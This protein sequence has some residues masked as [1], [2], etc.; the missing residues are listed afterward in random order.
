MHL[1]MRRTERVQQARLGTRRTVVELTV[2]GKRQG[3]KVML[4]MMSERV[5][6]TMKPTIFRYWKGL[7]QNQ[8]SNT[9]HSKRETIFGVPR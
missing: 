3:R 5:G 8:P 9:L 1:R 4:L 2:I 6:R 7:G